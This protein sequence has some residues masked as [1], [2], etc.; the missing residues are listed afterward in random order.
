MQHKR[1]TE[2]HMHADP[3][4]KIRLQLFW[5]IVTIIIFST[6]ISLR[7]LWSSRNFFHSRCNRCDEFILVDCLPQGMLLM[8]KRTKIKII[9][10]GRVGEAFCNRPK[11][12]LLL[13]KNEWMIQWI[14]W[15]AATS[16][17][18]KHN[19]GKCIQFHS[20]LN[21]LDMQKKKG[22]WVAEK[23][24]AFKKTWKHCGRLWEKKLS[25]FNCLVSVS[26]SVICGFW[27]IFWD[28]SGRK[29]NDI[30]GKNL[31]RVCV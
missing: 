11:P 18:G 20:T 23:I 19:F 2:L 27:M 25:L 8:K 4:M 30:A 1:K 3:Q 14:G 29:V 28:K 5:S 10:H 31:K 15:T 6:A 9:A 12:K 13:Q 26:R 21:F 7:R 24:L 16:I 22:F 17:V